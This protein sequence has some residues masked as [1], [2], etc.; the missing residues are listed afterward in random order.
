MVRRSH[1]RSVAAMKMMS[2]MAKF[3]RQR[4]IKE[5]YID[6]IPQL[7]HYYSAVGLRVSGEQFLHP[8]NG[9]SIPMK[10]D[11]DKYYRR[12]SA[13][14]SPLRMLQFYTLAKLHKFLG[15]ID[16]R[17]VNYQTND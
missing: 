4:G 11:V 13:D 10:L 1:R 3:G 15:K 16:G 12:L 6:C 17:W 8:E 7:A 9:V 14:P 2:H 5:T